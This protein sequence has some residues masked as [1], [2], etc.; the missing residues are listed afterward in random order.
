M[1]ESVRR[2][3]HGHLVVKFE[4]PLASLAHQGGAESQYL[5]YAIARALDVAGSGRVLQSQVKVELAGTMSGV[6]TGRVLAHPKGRTF[7]HVDRQY[8]QLH[9]AELITLRSRFELPSTTTA[10]AFPLCLLDSRQRRGAAIAVPIV[11]D[12]GA[13]R[14]FHYISRFTRIDHNTVRG[15]LKDPVI[16]DQIL[17]R[18]TRWAFGA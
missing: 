16:L 6:Q 2:D 10:R 13:P 9:A 7:W 5:A 15:W 11:A 12:Q 1:S 14:S 18:E 4:A 3:E 8:L 17:R